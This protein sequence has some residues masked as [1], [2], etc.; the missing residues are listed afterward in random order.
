MEP[1]ARGLLA[2]AFLVTAMAGAA[3]ADCTCRA[4]GV[5]AEHGQ[6]LC[7]RTPEGFRLARCDKVSNIASWT[8]LDETCP[9]IASGSA[10]QST[11]TQASAISR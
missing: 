4:R 8:F 3:E 1:A 10:G 9:Q 7:I 6:T 5:V 2:A 11:P